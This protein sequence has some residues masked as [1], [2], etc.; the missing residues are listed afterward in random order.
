MKAFKEHL[1]PDGSNLLTVNVLTT[2]NWP[3]YHRTPCRIPDSLSRELD[4]FTRFYKVK[5]A[6]RS[7]A[8]MHALDQCTL[9]AEFS[10]GPGGGRKELNVS[11][12]Q[13]IILLL[14]NDIGEEEKIGFKEIVEQTGLGE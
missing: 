1:G 2:G 8:Y 3:T 7:L 6:G 11:F 14:F 9:R 10:K 5:Y 13:A 12:Y 4:R